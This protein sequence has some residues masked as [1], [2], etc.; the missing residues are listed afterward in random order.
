LKAAFERLSLCGGTGS[1]PSLLDQPIKLSRRTLWRSSQPSAA[2][3]D[4]AARTALLLI[5]MVPKHSSSVASQFGHPMSLPFSH[6]PRLRIT[7]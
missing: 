1:L 3:R 2:S 6:S 7:S 4:I 5:S